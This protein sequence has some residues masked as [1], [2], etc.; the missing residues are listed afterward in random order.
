MGWR[1]G[2]GSTLSSLQYERFYRV[3][4]F[5]PPELC[6]EGIIHSILWMIKY[7]PH[8]SVLLQK[9]KRLHDSEAES[10][11]LHYIPINFTFQ[12][13]GFQA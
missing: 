5:L 4:S 7:R 3:S 1:D 11:L 2:L 12:G 8:K 10:F 13:W 9:K 6:E